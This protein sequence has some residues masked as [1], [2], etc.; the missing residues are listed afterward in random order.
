MTTHQTTKP[1]ISYGRIRGKKGKLDEVNG[2]MS[3][4]DNCMVEDIQRLTLSV[5]EMLQLTKRKQPCFP[6]FTGRHPVLGKTEV[7]LPLDS[8]LGSA[9]CDQ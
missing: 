9:F 5:H 8:R 4:E 3:V 7:P 2:E 1:Q 6:L